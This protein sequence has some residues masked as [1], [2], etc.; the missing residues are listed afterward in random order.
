MKKLQYIL[1]Y[2]E[3]HF[4]KITFGGFRKLF[5][6]IRKLLNDFGGTLLLN[7]LG[8]LGIMLCKFVEFFYVE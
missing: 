2:F 6:A 1:A 5:V 3:R 7:P 8:C 4:H